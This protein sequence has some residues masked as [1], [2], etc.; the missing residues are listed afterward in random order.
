[1]KKRGLFITG[2]DT[3]AGKTY[4]S[5]LIIRALRA[6]GLN[7]IGYKPICCGDRNDAVEFA[8]ASGISAD[9]DEMMNKINPV[10]MKTPA[11][12]HVAAMFE[13]SPIEKQ[14]LLDG[15]HSHVEKHDCVI[16]EG[17]FYS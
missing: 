13:N 15:Y 1:M 10:W 4:V 2:T 6:E 14:Q 5:S 12:P 17:L 16:T 8:D 11:A 3:D 7:T 9:D